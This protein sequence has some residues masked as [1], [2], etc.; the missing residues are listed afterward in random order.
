LKINNT[1]NTRTV[2][3]AFTMWMQAEQRAAQAKHLAERQVLL[4]QNSAILD[5]FTRNMKRPMSAAEAQTLLK[6][7][8][9]LDIPEKNAL[10][11]R[12]VTATPMVPP[13]AKRFEA[14]SLCDSLQC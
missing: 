14:D 10:N 2:S 5:D 4:R 3:D 12:P 11:L 13:T 9:G 7:T 1:T 6:A 8:A